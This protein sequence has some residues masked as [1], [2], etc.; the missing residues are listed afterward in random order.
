MAGT[1]ELTTGRMREISNNLRSQLDAYTK[2]YTKLHQIGMEMDKM[3]EG[4]ASNKFQANMTNDQERFK[5][6]ATI[7]N[8]YIEVLNR[9]IQTYSKAEAE[10]LQTIN[11]KRK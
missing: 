3:W 8:S 7:I 10:V 4:E 6:L 11:S 9:D 1:T 2:A 5:A